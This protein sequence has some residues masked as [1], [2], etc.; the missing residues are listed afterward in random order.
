MIAQVINCVIHKQTNKAIGIL[1]MYYS[2]DNTSPLS[3]VIF[4]NAKSIVPGNWVKLTII[5]R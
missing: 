4:F 5:N 1:V 2:E 3:R